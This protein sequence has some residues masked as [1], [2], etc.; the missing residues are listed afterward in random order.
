MDGGVHQSVP[1]PEDVTFL[2]STFLGGLLFL[3]PFGI[4]LLVLQEVIG[5]LTLVTTPLAS[6]FPKSDYFA[7]GLSTL[8]AWGVLIV[9]C[10]LTGLAARNAAVAG[11]S[12]KTDKFM[13]GMIPGYGMIRTRLAAALDN[14]AIAESRQVVTL[15]VGGLKRWAILIEEDPTE[16]QALVYLPNTPNVDVGTV[17]AVPLEKITKVD[18]P[19]HL[20]RSL[21]FYG[22]HLSSG[23]DGEA[24]SAEPL[25]DVKGK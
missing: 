18:V 20:L 4:L 11:V 25:P 13:S 23:P 19:A 3:I 9:L 8:I 17:G 7:I 5:F 24:A 14:E 21:E 10:F 1:V 12:S 2:K 16:G 22:Q 6:Q 15:E